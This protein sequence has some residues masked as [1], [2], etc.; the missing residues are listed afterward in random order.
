MVN[1]M[2]EFK[3][4]ISDPKSGKTYKT[5]VGGHH[6]NS[7]IGKGIGD[8]FDG[9]FVGLPGY[10]LVLT[11]GSDKEGFPMRRDLGGTGRRKIMIAKS[12]GFQAKL[13]QKK[14]KPVNTKAGRYP[15]MNG[16]R[17]R[18]TVRGNTISGEIIQINMRI[19]SYGPKDVS[20]VLK[21]KEDQAKAKEQKK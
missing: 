3:A 17:K 11:G 8:E 20:E 13:K 15:M 9:I 21:I 6:A 4:N 1:T 2:A 16:V 5:V 12:L 7:L 10:K 18:K 14:K 19:T